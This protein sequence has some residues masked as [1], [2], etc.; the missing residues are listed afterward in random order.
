MDEIVKSIKAFLYDR[1]VSPLFGA[2]IA[3]W[4]VCNYR[5]F[6]ALLDGD[7]SLSDKIKFLDEY[8]GTVTYQFYDLSFQVWGQVVHGIFWPSLLA[9]FYIYGYPFFAKPVYAYSL[10]KQK[11]L[12]DI[13]QERENNRLLTVEESRNL[14]KEIEQ[15]RYKADEEAQQFRTRI[16]SLTETINNLEARPNSTISPK[17]DEPSKISKNTLSIEEFKSLAKSKVN[18]LPDK[19]F[20]LSELLDDEGWIELDSSIRKMYGKWFKELVVNG[21]I[22][23]VV[24]GKKGTGNQQIYQKDSQRNSKISDES[25]NMLRSRYPFLTNSNINEELINK[26]NKYCVAN[27][28]SLDMLDILLP[29]VFADGNVGIMDLKKLVKGRWSNIEVDHTLKTLSDRGL[30][31][32]DEYEGEIKLTD[33]GKAMA[34]GSGLT[35]IQRIANRS[36]P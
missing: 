16:A 24:I 2:F 18:E 30:I 17:P 22:G 8:F 33:P 19:E 35:E 14:Q 20:E 7:A 12:R 32:R 27:Q 3:A 29:L 1:T 5:V 4:S 31:Y 9:I 15:L 13:K 34:V 26:L 23:D 11:E 36:K 28:I 10:T 21:E 25:K 6:V